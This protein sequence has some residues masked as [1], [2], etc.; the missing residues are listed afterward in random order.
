MDCVCKVE[1]SCTLFDTFLVTFRSEDYDFALNEIV[2][3]K[4]QQF[5]GIYVRIGYYI[6]DLYDPLVHLLLSFTCKPVFLVRP[7]SGDTFLGNFIH[8]S[9]ADLHLY[10][11]SGMA[12]KSTVKGFVSVVLR[13][14]YPVTYPVCLIFIH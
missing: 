7:V 4:I 14:V 6:L 12:H 5:K 9:G 3:Y 13:I 11:Y 10:P 8:S 1:R 2:M